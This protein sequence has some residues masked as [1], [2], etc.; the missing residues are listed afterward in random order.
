MQLLLNFVKLLKFHFPCLVL[1]INV[2]VL[3]LTS[4]SMDIKIDQVEH[5]RCPSR[6]VPSLSKQIFAS[7]VIRFSR[8]FNQTHKLIFLPTARASKRLLSKS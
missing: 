5:V 8:L 3:T 7:A 6:P 1:E 4:N 2:P